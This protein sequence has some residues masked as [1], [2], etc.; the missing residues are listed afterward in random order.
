[1]WRPLRPLSELYPDLQIGVAY[2]ARPAF[3][4]MMSIMIGVNLPLFAG[5]KQLA[6]RREMAA[7]RTMSQAELTNLRNETTAR[8]I[9][10][11][12]RAARDQNL[13][14][15]YRTSIV[16]QARAAVQAALA[17]YRVGRVSFMQLV[18]NQ[19]TVNG[20]EAETYRLIADYHQ[21]VGELE[22]LVGQPL[23]EQP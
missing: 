1:M 14:H 17:S 5:S 7:M 9:E 16:P 6:M 12:A 3:E 22:A 15:L 8:I 2:Q 18:D 10:M 23:E 4:D 19:M 20:Y 21:A 11:R 13:A